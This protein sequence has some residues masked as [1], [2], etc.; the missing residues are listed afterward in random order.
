MGLRRHAVL[1]V[2]LAAAVGCG[3][4]RTTDTQRAASEMLLVSQA[5]DTA[6]GQIDFAPLS[7]RAVFL[8]TQF[9]D[10]TVDKGYVIGSL[11]QHLLAHGAYLMDERGKAQYVVEPRSGGIGTDRS[12][13]LVGTP[14]MSLPAVVPGMPTSIPEVALVKTTDQK[15]V[16]KL[17]VFAYHRQTGR[18]LWQ[19]GLVQGNSNMKDRWLFGAGP[20]STGSIKPEGEFAGGRVPHLP[21]PFVHSKEREQEEAAE[22]A[23]LAAREAARQRRTFADP[24]TPAAPPAPLAVLGVVGGVAGDRPLIHPRPDHPTI[25]IPTVPVSGPVP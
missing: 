11:R 3:T 9:L 21:L 12:G 15:G 22:A 14:A 4:T 6:V 19:S 17:A 5:V 18:P 8:D 2:G 1:A 25:I 7:G 20:Y 23:L 24:D 13:L 10:G 16:A